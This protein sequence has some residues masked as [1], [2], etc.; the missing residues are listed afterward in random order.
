WRQQQPALVNGDLAQLDIGNEQLI[1][2]VREYEGERLLVVLNMTATTQYA[3]LETKVSE[4]LKGNGFEAS[5]D[6]KVLTLPAYQACYA[7]LS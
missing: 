5:L 2:L 6:G 3:H 1:A 4:V 7:V